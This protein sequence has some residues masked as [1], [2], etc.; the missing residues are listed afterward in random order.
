MF[1]RLTWMTM[2]T[3]FG[4]GLALWCRRAVRVRVERYRPA[5]LRRRIGVSVRGVGERLHAAADEGR[6]AMR[7]RE[8]QLRRSHAPSGAV[9]AHR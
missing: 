6:R 9:R 5:Q 3:G 4:F 8:E 7:E 1:K 2:G